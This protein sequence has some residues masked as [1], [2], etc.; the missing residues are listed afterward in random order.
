MSSLTHFAGQ[1]DLA[2]VQAPEQTLHLACEAAEIGLWDLDLLTNELTWSDR[3]KAMFGFSPSAVCTMRDFYSGLHPDD[4]AATSA[5]FAAA[6]D[7]GERLVYDVEYRTIGAEDGIIRWVAAK[8]RGVF[9]AQGRCVRAIGTAIDITARRAA[10]AERA[11]LAAIVEQSSDF[12]GFADRDGRLL[13]VNE[14][15]C[16]LLGLS[17]PRPDQMMVAHLF[18][19]DG[20][21]TLRD[22]IQPAVARQGSWEG[23]LVV[24]HATTGAPVE[25]QANLFVVRDQAGTAVGYGGVARDL[26]ERR[27]NEEAL[28]RMNETLEQQVAERTA[29]LRTNE[30]RLRTI[31][32]T[33]HQLQ[34]LL[35]VDGT[36]LD[37]N[38]IS[39]N[40]IGCTLAEVA[41]KKF[42]DSP[43]FAATPGLPDQVRAAVQAA[44]A[45][46]TTRRE[47]QAILPAGP[48]VFDFAVRPIHD[49]DGRVFAIV[50]DALDITERRAA[51]EAL[52]Q[53][54]KM[55]AFG[56]LTGGVAHDFNNL[57]Q[58]ITGGLEMLGRKH[59]HTEAG[60]KLLGLIGN[61]ADRGAQLTRQLLA[62]ARKE[63]LDARPTDVNA[64]LAASGQL[65]DR[66]LGGRVAIERVLTPDAWPAMTDPGQL[67]IAILNLVLNARDAMPDGGTITIS[68][69]N[70]TAPGEDCPSALSPGDYVRVSV[71]DTGVGMEDAVR[72]RVFEPFFTTK[73]VG[74]GTGLGLS[75]VYGFAHQS[76]GTVRI[77]S[78][79]G[80][81]TVV[82]IYLPRAH[83][84][85]ETASRPDEPSRWLGRETVLVV[86]DDADIRALAVASLRELG[87]RVL[88]AE[89]GAGALELL[90]AEPGI[91]LLLADFAMPGMNGAELVR[92]ARML[93][94]ELPVLFMTG[95]ADLDEVG[96][97][98]G[99][100]GVIYK[101]FRLTELGER[102]GQT[103]AQGWRT[104]AEA[105][106]GEVRAG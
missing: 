12:M 92:Q 95:Y 80:Q 45:G 49:E 99:P 52:R 24:R 22:R 105:A 91:D 38:A 59:V 96:A 50:P 21:A 2:W 42:W 69:G 63:H 101:P 25:V 27:R 87:Y 73:G 82:D 66:S 90:R 35:A 41:G 10:A 56:Q 100:D 83:G 61:A 7:P 78:V 34:G 58:A 13:F 39:L 89:R 37:A 67:D 79:P 26:T 102:V 6:I 30:A 76:S 46:Q 106:E 9:D 17:W 74:K 28:R 68:T 16:R 97:L 103:L 65:L 43:W 85:I 84:Q 104:G 75:Q 4:L 3:T 11:R 29:L 36:V 72:A 18:F 88:A 5:A 23:E 40:V 55:E 33:S 54:Q 71:A 93:R 86:D 15:G 64:T 94:P 20:L 70:V 48:R 32:E 60:Q 51:E 8:G 77:A 57:L 81:G 47:V 31:F 14:A 62:F 53:S 98:A 1:A 44:A 19:D